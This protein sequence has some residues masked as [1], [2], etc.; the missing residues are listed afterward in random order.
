MES[1]LLR[2]RLRLLCKC[3]YSGA[4]PNQFFHSGSVYNS[5]P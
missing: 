3:K 5:L 4:V 1:E 2:L